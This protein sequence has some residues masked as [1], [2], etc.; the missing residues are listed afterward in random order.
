MKIRTFLVDDDALVSTGI[1]MIVSGAVDIDIIG[2]AESGEQALPH[3]REVRPDVVV[4][5][6]HLTGISGLEVTERI[7]KG[8][9]GARGEIE[10]VLEDGPIR[11][12]VL[13]AGRV[14]GVGRGGTPAERVDPVR[15]AGRGE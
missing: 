5:D 2:E 14:A 15:G 6:M 13:S 10:S 11:P 4:C 9:Y 12:R 7:M 8:E 1:R 3:I